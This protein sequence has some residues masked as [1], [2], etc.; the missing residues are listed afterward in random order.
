MCIHL[1]PLFWHVNHK[2]S[3]Q[4]LIDL[5]GLFQIL[6]LFA[7]YSQ[8]NLEKHETIFGFRLRVDISQNGL[9]WVEEIN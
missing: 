9:K 2:V 6:V 5:N 8:T 1:R 3:S 7:L 4:S